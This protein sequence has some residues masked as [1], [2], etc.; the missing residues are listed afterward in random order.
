MIEVYPPTHSRGIATHVHEISKDLSKYN[1]ICQCQVTKRSIGIR[2]DF[3]MVESIINNK[4]MLALITNYWKNSP[5][6]GVRVYTTKLMECLKKLNPSLDISVI[7]REG[8]DPK[9]YCPSKNKIMFMLKAV[10]YLIKTKPNAI[11]AQGG[12]FTEIPAVVY[13][14]FNKKTMLVC[15]QHTEPERKLPFY[16]RFLYNLTLN[17][18]DYVTF[19]SEDLQKKIKE[20]AGLNIK[21]KKVITYAGVK[22]KEVSG[23]EIKKFCERFDIKDNSLILSALG[24]TALRYKAEGAKLLIKAVRK[25]RG[26]YPNIILILT[27]EGSYSKELKEFAKS[28][29]V[30]DSVIFTGDVDDPYVPLS[31]CDIYAHITLGEGG[32]SLALL[33]AMS[34]EKTIIATSA[35]GIPEVIANNEN[36]ILVETNSEAIAEGISKLLKD[37]KLASTLGMNAKKTVLKKFTWEKC[38]ERFFNL[39]FGDTLVERCN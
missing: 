15:T 32:L 4:I 6:G 16:K 38:A 10:R 13:K 12:W 22:S 31:I 28:E 20:V 37:R 21:S 18:F 11:H 5:G 7:F 24:L 8:V 30:Y 14:I 36:G 27:R 3:T 2:N 33:E 19:V 17:R 1:M 39:Y 25:L 29:G 26:N 34:M 23:E 9:N 35:G